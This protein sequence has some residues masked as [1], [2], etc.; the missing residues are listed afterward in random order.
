MILPPLFLCL[1]IGFVTGSKTQLPPVP[2]TVLSGAF[3]KSFNF[4]TSTSSYQVEGAWLDGDKGLSI[5]DAY[6]HTPGRIANNDTGDI[7]NDMY[8]LYPSDIQLMKKYGLQHYRFSIAWNRILPTGVAPVNQKAVDYYNDLINTL[9]ENGVTPHVTLYHSETPL[10]LTMYPNLPM[11]FLDSERFPTWFSDYAD[12]VFSLFGDRVK[13]W[14]TFNEPF[15]TAV[16]GTY[17]DTDPYLIAHNAILA[18]AQTVQLYRSK[19]EELQ[20]GTIGIVLNTA[21]FYPKD[22][23]SA[24]DIDAAQRGYDFWYGWFLDPMHTGDYPKR[25]RDTVGSR[26][27]VFSDEQK[28]MVIGSLDFVALNYYFPYITSP[29]T[30]TENDPPGF[31]RDMNITS[32]F[33]SSWP[34]SQTG[35]GIYGPGLRDLLIYT[36]EN[37]NN[38][39]TYVTENGLAWEESS[40]DAAIDDRERQQYLYDHIEAV[41]QALQNGCDVKGYFVWSFQ[42]NLEWA[43]GYQMHFGLIY[44]ERPSLQRIVKNSLRWY[45]NVL[46]EF[47][48]QK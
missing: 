11:P 5:W 31:F 4:G 19:Y 42:D 15:C 40:V 33:D 21:H 22:V 18:H 46:A 45:S 7:A 24:A 36:K 23:N 34:L 48:G 27:P 43:S 14:F 12:V 6:S 28:K 32:E 2:P 44:I 30:M 10:A 25:M 39:P 29:G 20:K 47:G 17:G 38:L 9:L 35:W 16:Y 1:F 37:Y 13:H 41:G 8:H 3:P 26:L